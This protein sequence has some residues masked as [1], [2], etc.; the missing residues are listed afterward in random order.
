MPHNLEL[1]VAVPD[2]RPFRR[3]AAALPGVRAVGSIRQVDRYFAVETG[4]LK[5]R[6]ARPGDAEL[7]RYQRPSVGGVRRSDYIRCPV[8]Q[9]ARLSK[10]LADAIGSSCIVRKTREVFLYRN[11]RI[12]L[13]R[14]V[15]LGTFVE[16]EVSVA[17]T[18]HHAIALMARLAR[19]LQLATSSTVGGSYRDL[20]AARS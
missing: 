18:K 16:I 9:P 6:T 13:D 5:L 8:Y 15:G 3:R 12:H 2:L 11:A 7:I 20:L 17:D 19:D 10:L 14:V 4:H 1:K